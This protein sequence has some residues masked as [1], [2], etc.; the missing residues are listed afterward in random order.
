MELSIFQMFEFFTTHLR[1]PISNALYNSN[2]FKYSFDFILK[3][4][5]SLLRLWNNENSFVVTYND[6]CISFSEIITAIILFIILYS[7]LK[8]FMLFYRIITKGLSKVC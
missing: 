8:I 3:F 4:V 1:I 2:F 5:N 6:F 7:F